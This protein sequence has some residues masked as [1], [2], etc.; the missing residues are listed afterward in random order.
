MIFPTKFGT[1][2][3][4]I[5]FCL[6]LVSMQSFSGLLFLVLGVMFACFV[7]NFFR[8]RGSTRHIAVAPP[9]SIT[10]SEG[11]R[12]RDAWTVANTGD[13]DIGHL[14][15]FGP[16]GELMAIGRLAAGEERHVTPELTFERRGVYPFSA[17]R[18]RSTFPYGLLQH[19]RAMRFAGE[20]LVFPALFPCTPPVAAG[21]EPML[22]GRFTGKFKS[23]TG[24]NFHGVRPFQPRDP[25]RLIH[26]PS[27]SKGQ[28]IMVKEFDEEL[29]GRVSIV[30]DNRVGTT[31]DGETML[32]W[33]ARASGSLAFAALDQGYQV[34][35][36]IIGAD[37]VISIPPFADGDVILEALARLQPADK[38]ND[39]ARL[40]AITAA[41]SQ[42]SGLS[43]V[44]TDDHPEDLA[45]VRELTSILNRKVQVYIA[46]PAFD[47]V[48]VQY[49]DIT[50]RRYG[51][52]GVL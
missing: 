29:S 2:I 47:P 5:S 50:L 25:V 13:A 28:G 20:V 30:V 37:D 23:Q 49:P 11:D 38:Q 24:D 52:R 18:A 6:Y 15:L 17:L 33:A 34:E 22:G 36:A 10:C 9:G 46:E 43:V 1:L 44:L 32:D 8:A 21:F 39:L 35:F 31:I 45:Y 27:S 16:W 48:V 7:V 12:I 3:L 40:P 26:W 51:A 14:R 42:K 19:R 41:L 4:A